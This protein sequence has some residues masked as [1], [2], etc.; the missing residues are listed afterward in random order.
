MTAAIHM[1]AARPLIADLARSEWTKL[2]TLRSTGWTLLAA[3]IA[4]VGF[5]GLLAAA[6]ARH[7]APATQTSLDPAA[8]SESGFFLAQLA[9][10]VLGVLMLTG[11]YATGSIRS[12]LAA[13]PQ[14]LTLLAAKASMFTAVA[15][16]VGLAS[17]F[18]A[19][20]IGRAIFAGKGIHAHLTDPS[21]LRSVFGAAGYLAIFE[22]FSLSLGALIRRTAGAIAVLITV[23]I[24]LSAS[25]GALP[26]AWQDTINPYL[27]SIAGQSITGRT[28][29]TPVGQ[30]H[31]L[32][33]WTNFTIF[34]GYTAAL[35]IAAAIR[36]YHRDA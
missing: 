22:L 5:G 14:R 6:Y 12:T 17:S 29:F 18:A 27:P 34:C 28:K 30:G 33:P 25:I 35:L 1:R 7:L 26:L 19:F 16:T 9:I 13:A 3:A 15:F 36:L 20:Y 11:E 4:M 10:G 2:R 8:H 23:L 32:S 21:A 31:L 24:F